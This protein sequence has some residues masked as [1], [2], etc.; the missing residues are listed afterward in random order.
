MTDN[1]HAKHGPALERFTGRRDT[2]AGARAPVSID[3]TSFPAEFARLRA[4]VIRPVFEAVGNT[5]KERGDEFTVSEE[6]DRRISI[7]IVPA[8]AKKSIHPN[9][10]F[11]TLTF[12]GAPIAC[13]I[14]I[15]GRNMR[16]NSEVSSGSRGIYSPA[17][18]NKELVE[19]ELMKFIGEI[20]NW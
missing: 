5:L 20:G 4:S 15:Q 14:G 3:E 7:H 8:G 10:W 9:D 2:S 6:E 17:Q 12:F 11:P 1:S 16:P 13:T 18:I 19:K